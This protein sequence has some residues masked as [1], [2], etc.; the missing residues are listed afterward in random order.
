MESA[1]IIKEDLTMDKLEEK[2]IKLLIDR[3]LSFA[4]SKILFISYDV[5]NQDFIDKLQRY[6]IDKGIEVYLQKNDI[7]QK[8]DILKKI[9]LEDIKKEEYF[10][11]KDWDEYAKKDA[12]FLMIASEFPGVMDDIEAD[13]IAEASKVRMATKKVYRQKQMDNELSWLIAVFP[14]KC[15]AKAKFPDLSTEEAYEKLFNLMME[16]VLCQEKDP[17]V[18]WNKQLEKQSKMM[19]KLNELKIKSLH[20]KNKL[21]T[22]LKIGLSSEALW[23]SAG[24]NDFK[25]IVNMPSYEVFTSPDK[26]KTEGIVYASKPLMYNSSLIEDF[27]VE[28]KDGKVINYDAKTGKDILKGL[29]EAEE[30]MKYLGECALVDKNSP[31]AKTN[32]VFGE[33]CLDENASCHIALGAGFKECIANSDKMNKEKLEEIG[34]NEAANHVDFMIGTDDLS[35]EAETNEGVVQIFKD[36]TFNI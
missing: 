21:G 5:A 20:Y 18:A 10:T 23:Q 9:K 6:A 11:S 25:M 13:K 12:A 26:T 31:I 28:F 4:K 17:I 30:G 3:C 34:L 1:I 36:G 19:Q 22:D 2:Y 29:I 7:Y 33:T 35:I 32:F 15:W 14:N 24:E 8:H 16:V 27:W